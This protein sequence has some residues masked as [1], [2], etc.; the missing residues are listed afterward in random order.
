MFTSFIICLLV[1]LLASFKLVAF[2]VHH[3]AAMSNDLGGVG[4]EMN[5]GIVVSSV[6]WTGV[7]LF[8]HF[9]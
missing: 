7:V 2:I 5:A 8:Y 4:A 6:A 1:A 3:H 9:V